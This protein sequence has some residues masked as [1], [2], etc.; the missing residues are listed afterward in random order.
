MWFD[1]VNILHLHAN[2][3]PSVV[4][5]L[6]TIQ[7]NDTLSNNTLRLNDSYKHQEMWGLL[8]QAMKLKKLL[9]K[10]MSENCWVSCSGSNGFWHLHCGNGTWLPYA[11]NGNSSANKARVVELGFEIEFATHPLDVCNHLYD[12]GGWAHSIFIIVASQWAPWR[13]KSSTSRVLAP[14]FVQ[15][16]MKENVKTPRHWPLWGESTDDRWI[17]ITSNAGN[18]SIWWRHQV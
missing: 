7:C 14:P 6:G 13:L 18:V 16:H 9:L 4:D 5:Y 3:L 8:V 10:L 17:P 2:G 12:I 15:A 11:H 1:L